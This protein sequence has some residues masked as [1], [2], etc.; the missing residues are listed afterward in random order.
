MFMFL[1][2]KQVGHIDFAKLLVILYFCTCLYSTRVGAVPF[3]DLREQVIEHDIDG[4]DL[5]P[6]ERDLEM[7]DSDLNSMQQQEIRR[8]QEDLSQARTEVDT[9][10]LKVPYGL[11]TRE[12]I[13]G[14]LGLSLSLPWFP[15]TPILT[16]A[17]FRG[18]PVS[19]IGSYPV[20]SLF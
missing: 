6:S 18:V 2:M 14:V 17:K 20:S 3:R 1:L 11:D 9:L 12:D 8:L 19:K 5:G 7:S 13:L 4:I 15:V 16:P 10:R